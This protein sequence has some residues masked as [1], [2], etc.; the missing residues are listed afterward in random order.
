MNK[1]K[2]CDVCGI[3]DEVQEYEFLGQSYL[4]CDTCRNAGLFALGLGL[5][6]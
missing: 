3:T 6:D 4:L 5:I 1:T 2:R